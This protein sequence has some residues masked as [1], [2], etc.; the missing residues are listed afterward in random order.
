MHHIDND[1]VDLKTPEAFG[2]AANTRFIERVLNPEEQRL[3]YNSDH[4]DTIVWALWAAKETAFK[5][6]NKSAPDITSA[7][8]RYPV[9]FD[10]EKTS[11]ILS[12]IVDTPHGIVP[13]KTF[14]TKAYVHC[15]GTT[16]PAISLE[17]ILYGM[18]EI[19]PE[20]IPGAASISD[21]ESL[22]VRRLAKKHMASCL[23]LKEQDIQ[24]IR[25]KTKNRIH[26]PKVYIKGHAENID[27]SLSHDGWFIAYSFLTD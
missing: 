19:H 27:I 12:G 24:I 11:G 22:S 25:H 8:R 3:L 23:R 7:P 9:R 18:D 17:S 5:A 15:I 26:P 21:Q 13:V 6:V 20:I 1:I 4:P 14:I 16:G 2:K 10:S